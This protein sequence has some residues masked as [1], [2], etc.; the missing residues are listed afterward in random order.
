MGLPPLLS[1]GLGAL[2]AAVIY[3]FIWF[4]GIHWLT[5]LQR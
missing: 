3:A 4:V 2:V 5:G 1:G